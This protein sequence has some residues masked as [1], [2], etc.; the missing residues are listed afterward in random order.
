MSTNQKIVTGFDFIVFSQHYPNQVLLEMNSKDQVGAKAFG[1]KDLYLSWVPKYFI[2][3][4]AAFKFWKN[5][6]ISGGGLSASETQW[7]CNKTKLSECISLVCEGLY[8]TLIIRSSVIGETIL[9]RGTYESKRCK[10]TESALLS[11]LCEMWLHF[12]NMQNDQSLSQS[13]IALLIQPFI[14]SCLSGH[15]SNER[16]V[17]KNQSEW[18]CEFDIPSGQGPATVIRFKVKPQL[19]SY[20]EINL[21]CENNEHLIIQLKYVA[22]RFIDKTTRCHI[23]WLWDGKR[24]WVVQR[25]LEIQFNNIPPLSKWTRRNCGYDLKELNIFVKEENVRG[26]WPKVNSVRTFRLCGLPTAKIFVLENPQIINDLCEKRVDIKLIYDLEELTKIPIVIRSDVKSNDVQTSLLLPRTDAINT[27]SNATKFLTDTAS[28]F[29]TLGFQS[30]QFCFIAHRFIAASS[31]A[32]SISKPGITR[33]RIDSCWGMPDGLF[34]YPHD[35]YEVDIRDSRKIKKRIRCKTDFLDV[36][37]NGNFIAV[38]CSKPLDWR[39]SLKKDEI[40]DIA[41][42]SQNV[43]DYLQKTV[44]VMYFVG[45]DQITGH[46]SCLPWYYLTEG[47]PQYDQEIH[48]IR[49]TGKKILITDEIDINNLRER[50]KKGELSGIVSIRLRPRVELLRSKEFISKVSKLALEIKFPVELEGSILSHMFYMMSKAGVRVRYVDPFDPK[51]K[52]KLIGKLVRDLIPVRIES[53]GEVA[54]VFKLSIDDL[55]PMLKAKAVE[56]ALEF[57]W[58]SDPLRMFEELTDLLEVIESACY[59]FGRNFIELSK[60][61]DSKKRERGGFQEGI[62]LVETQEVPLIS[63]DKSESTFFEVGSFV[64]KKGTTIKPHRSARYKLQFRKPYFTGNDIILSLIPPDPSEK[65]TKLKFSVYN[66]E[67]E[68][69]IKYQSKEI[70]ISVQPLIKPI[71]DPSQL[72]FDFHSSV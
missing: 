40:Y 16:R 72:F 33:V 15:L 43:S 14:K 55:I 61:K 31:C 2:V 54:R 10:A 6:H 7:F 47:L 35:S 1:L 63:K 22:G 36:D 23:E 29:H 13:E 30:D 68:V 12:D 11:A 49:Y 58:E 53:H 21:L 42:S 45:V 24:L 48:E 44:Q 38:H 27:V 18:L 5:A 34:F 65:I 60:L 59:S 9:E 41:S 4:T 19:N 64:G 66:D 69:I 71:I 3:T 52:K 51:P 28:Y 39:S 37:E 56:E 26:D 67:Y 17:S 50:Y 70:I 25:D 8:D 20:P 57:Y 46:P 32:L 62:I